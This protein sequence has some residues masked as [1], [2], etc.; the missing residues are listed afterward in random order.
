MKLIGH[1]GHV[2]VLAGP[3]LTFQAG[4]QVLYLLIFQRVWSVKQLTLTLRIIVVNM[5]CS[6]NLC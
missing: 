6:V 2:N 3:Y 1:H 5:L 4:F